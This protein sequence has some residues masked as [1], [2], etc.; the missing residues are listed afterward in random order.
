MQTLTRIGMALALA[1]TACSSSGQP[2]NG[3]DAARPGDALLADDR[4]E[5]PSDR[6][7]P[8]GGDANVDAMDAAVANDAGAPD[9]ADASP[10]TDLGAMPPSPDA[11]VSPDADASPDADVAPGATDAPDVPDLPDAPDV[12]DLP[13]APDGGPIDRCVGASCDDANPCTV[14]TCAPAIGCVHGDAPDGPPAAS[15][16]T[17][18]GR[19]ACRATGRTVCRLGALVDTCAALA[20][21]PADDDCDGVDD[22]CNG[23]AD[24]G[25]VPRA[26]ACGSGACA[27]AGALTCVGGAEVDSCRPG[28]PPCAAP[29]VT[30][31]A[32]PPA[33]GAD[34]TATFRWTYANDPA[35]VRF[36]TS[37]GYDSGVVGA[38]RSSFVRSDLRPGS[39][40]FTV[41]ATNAVGSGS[42]TYAWAVTPPPVGGGRIVGG[43]SAGLR[44]IN[45]DGSGS[46]SLGPD[47]AEIAQWSPD[48]R[49]VAYRRT[50]SR[51][52]W[53]RRAD[54]SEPRNLSGA[55]LINHFAWSP[56][57]TTL[58]FDVIAG[59][60]ADLHTIRVD[61]SGPRNLTQTAAATEDEATFTPDGRIVY[62]NND[63]AIWVMNADGTAPA[64]LVATTA[65]D[66]VLGRPLF[67]P[68]G[69]FLY[70]VNFSG[71]LLRFNA[72]GSGRTPIGG[73]AVAYTE[74][75]L[76]SDGARIAF[77]RDDRV[78]VIDDAPGAAT[79]R[80][81]TPAAAGAGAA[82]QITTW[83][84]DGAA[85]VFDCNAATAAGGRLC[86]V[87]A[88]VTA[89]TAPT[90]I[91]TEPYRFPQWSGYNPARGG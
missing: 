41:T 77:L 19:G 11:A 91:G 49:F 22:D 69:R 1:V 8:D 61:G 73:G 9:A 79:V 13:D 57:S 80:A 18:C 32:T 45:A 87:D 83:S 6:G 46:A 59:G 66:P 21:A 40:T 90:F 50:S 64:R 88:A 53:V 65:T 12:P 23:A 86:R 25:Y 67:S 74:F 63:R 75:S 51:A 85:V 71:L 54:G 27:A 34:T 44:T 72:D 89:P 15:V 62:R 42:A 84:P 70:V 78:W 48:G 14:D 58:V 68:D 4:G 28:A 26:T 16:A 33:S 7:A 60:Y 81:L 76:S 10:A 17:S 47:D 55:G 52:L 31:T 20:P 3:E 43:S 56:D 37:D 35:T 5:A 82:Y 24:D 36:T 30:F 2:A 38:E 29:T 39:Y